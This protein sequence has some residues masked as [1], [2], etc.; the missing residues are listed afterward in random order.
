MKQVRKSDILSLSPCLWEI[1]RTFRP[2]MRVPA[3]IIAE[4]S[5]LDEI[6]GDRSLQQLVNVTTLPG[7]V[8]AAF[9]MSTGR[10]K[11]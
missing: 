8:K 10:R 4:E 2:G 5:L 3:R 6:I 9:V 11:L 1:P 7:I